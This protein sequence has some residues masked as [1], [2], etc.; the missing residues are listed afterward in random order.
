MKQRNLS[1]E[2]SQKNQYD[3]IMAVDY[4]NNKLFYGQPDSKKLNTKKLYRRL[5]EI[6]FL[7]NRPH[8]R[9]HGNTHN[10]PF[11]HI[12]ERGWA[13]TK[14]MSYGC[15][16]SKKITK[17]YYIPIFTAQGMIEIEKAIKNADYQLPKPIPAA[18]KAKKTVKNHSA[19]KRIIENLIANLGN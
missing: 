19:G 16:P 7:Q 6:Q 8:E 15:G 17:Y 18:Y 13:L 9:C 10:M 3:I 1:E 14:Q 2:L 5:R 11:Q 12:K 4:F